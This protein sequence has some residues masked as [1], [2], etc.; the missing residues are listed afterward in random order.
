MMKCRNRVGL[1]AFGVIGVVAPALGGAIPSPYVIDFFPDETSINNTV[2]LVFFGPGN[3]P[4][5]AVG[6]E[7]TNVRLNIEFTT[8]GDFQAENLLINLI[9]NSG[10]TFISVSGADLGWSG[11]GTFSDDVNFSDL[12]GIIGPG[13]WNF[14]LQSVE[15]VGGGF[16]AYSGSFSADTR[17]EVSLIPA[18]GAAGLLAF[19]GLVGS[20]R[21]R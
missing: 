3:L 6:Y 4:N 1:A 5:A 12:N 17:F 16:F 10:T 9:A 20:R 13:L 8:A 19:A 2:Q 11:Q 15:P 18:P 21:R 7:I 14:E